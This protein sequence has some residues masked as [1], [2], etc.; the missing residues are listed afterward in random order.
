MQGFLVQFIQLLFQALSFALLARVLLSWIDP[1]GNWRVTELVRETT[2][3][4][5]APIRSVLPSLG[6]FDFSPLIA[7]LLLQF[8]GNLVIGALR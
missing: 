2:E 8:V 7:L 3:P 6:G 1:M 4:I 5:L